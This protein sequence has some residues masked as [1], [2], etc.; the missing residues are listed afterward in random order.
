[1]KR[2][3]VQL[4]NMSF[5]FIEH[6]NL[7]NKRV[8]HTYIGEKY[9]DEIKE[10][11]A[12]GIECIPIKSN[13]ALDTEVCAHADM[14]VFNCGKGNLIA[15]K[16]AIGEFDGANHQ[17]STK[18][19]NSPYPNDISLNCAFIGDVIVCNSKYT[20]PLILDYAKENNIKIFHTNQGYSKCS[21]CILNK[22]AVI[23]DDNGL[24]RLLKK[25]QLDVLEIS[26]G[27]IFLSDKHYGFI[28][29]TSAKI[30]KNQ[31]YFSGDLSSHRDYYAIIAFLNKY[32]IEPI[33]NPNRRLQDFG[34]LVQLTE[35]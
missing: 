12:L 10:L 17:I 32:N 28:G 8:L 1:M 4:N 24:A 5:S 22:N 14:L 27:D 19:V 13:M 15:S 33:F 2:S 34:G 21:I 35:H 3:S 7:P 11:T 26:S 16:D 25:Y 18:T 23:T 30:S 6:P 9:T 29:G 31:I 20:E